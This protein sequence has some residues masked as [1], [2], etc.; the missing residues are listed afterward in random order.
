MFALPGEEE[1][2]DDTSAATSAVPEPVNITAKLKA[3][4][5]PRSATSTGFVGLRNQ[6]ATC[7][8]NSLLQAHF[9]TPE[10]R[11][12]IFAFDPEADL[13]AGRCA[14]IAKPDEEALKAFQEDKNAKRAKAARLLPLQLQRLFA[15][16]RALDVEGRSTTNLTEIGFQWTGRD[17]RVQH[18][19]QDLNRNMMD[20]L[21]K[22]VGDICNDRT[23]NVRD[24]FMCVPAHGAARRRGRACARECVVVWLCVCVRGV[25]AAGR[26]MHSAPASVWLASLR[27]AY[28]VSKSCHPHSHARAHANND[29][30]HAGTHRC[31]M[32][33]CLLTSLRSLR[34]AAVGWWCLLSAKCWGPGWAGLGRSTIPL[35]IPRSLQLHLAVLHAVPALRPQGQERFPRH[36]PGPDRARAGPCRP[37]RRLLRDAEVR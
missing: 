33:A 36:R 14:W 1:D 15:E 35:H 8:M 16:L 13:G 22:S 2:L 5:K 28:S 29:P 37:R 7:Y 30:R 11:N 27:R 3:P 26:C 19:V 10:F 17:G 4:P 18:D 21:E 6:G 24:I 31:D 34:P 32:W 12:F 23:G 25:R 9:M 20:W